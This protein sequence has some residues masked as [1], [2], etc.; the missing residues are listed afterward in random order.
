VSYN[1]S[2]VR[3]P[4]LLDKTLC[5]TQE[6]V[7]RSYGRFPLLSASPIP[8]PCVCHPFCSS[9]FS[10]FLKSFRIRAPGQLSYLVGHPVSFYLGHPCPTYD[11][12][13]S[14]ASMLRARSSYTNVSPGLLS[15]TTTSR[16]ARILRS[17]RSTPVRDS[18]VAHASSRML[19]CARF[20]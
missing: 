11:D 15:T 18:P 13:S 5:V 19:I 20:T 7:R 14:P 8:Y 9:F 3:V 10:N 17:A 2:F 1:P 4:S 6:P 16:P 12:T